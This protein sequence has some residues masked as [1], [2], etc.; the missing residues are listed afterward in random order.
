MNAIHLY[1]NL[2]ADPELRTVGANNTAIVKFNVAVKRNMPDKNGEYPVDYIPCQMWGKRGETLARYFAKGSSIVLTG[3]L[4]NN[5]YTDKNGNK[6]YS[7]VVNVSNFYFV[8]SNK[9]SP[10]A[11]G[12]QVTYAAPASQQIS[13]FE[14]LGEFEEVVGDGSL[15]F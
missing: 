10:A 13:D 14:S 4:Q 5:N 15:P 9:K 7:F 1:G 3:E 2:V 6:V 8:N 11:R 12:E